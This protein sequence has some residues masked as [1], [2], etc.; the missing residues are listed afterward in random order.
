MPLPAPI[1]WKKM[2]EIQVSYFIWPKVKYLETILCHSKESLLNYCKSW[3]S[4]DEAMYIHL[5]H[6][7]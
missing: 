6:I 7:M 1:F 4:W 3:P 2:D 5:D